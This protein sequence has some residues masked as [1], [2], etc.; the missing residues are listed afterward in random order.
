MVDDHD[1]VGK[2]SGLVQVVGADRVVGQPAHSGP[3]EDDLD[4]ERELARQ[5]S[6]LD[7]EVKLNESD[8]EALEEHGAVS[9]EVARAMA[10]GVRTRL[11]SDWGIGITGIAG[12]TGGTDDKPVGLVYWAVAG[13]GGVWAEDRVFPGDRTV[14]REWSLNSSLDLLRRRAPSQSSA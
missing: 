10:S 6:E 13:P 12:P 4:D 9:E 5:A 14:V 11:E 3:T 7:S 8:L 1:V 2:T